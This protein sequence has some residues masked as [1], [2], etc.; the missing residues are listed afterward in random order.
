MLAVPGGGTGSGGGA[1]W[2]KRPVPA[3][4]DGDNRAVLDGDVQAVPAAQPG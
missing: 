4:L 3:V 1:G 2:Q